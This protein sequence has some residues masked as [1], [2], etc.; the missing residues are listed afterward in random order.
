MAIRY[1]GHNSE[2]IIVDNTGKIIS[3]FS[4]NHSLNETGMEV[5]HWHE[6]PDQIY[7]ITAAI[8]SM[9]P[10]R[11]DHFP[12]YHPLLALR[13]WDGIT[14]FPATSVAIHAKT[15][16]STTPGRRSVTSTHQNHLTN[17]LT[18]VILLNP[19]NTMRV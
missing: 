14:G 19:D 3:R 1:K 13:K 15:S 12:T 18:R 10:A 16:S 17:R 8:S 5:I 2:I 7:S 6:R 11:S 4:V 9:E